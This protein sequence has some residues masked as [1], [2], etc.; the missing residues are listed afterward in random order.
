MKRVILT[1]ILVSACGGQIPQDG[2]Q[3]DLRNTDAPPITQVSDGIYRGK[4]PDLATLQKLVDMGVQYDIDLEDDQTA[5]DN[6][7]QMAAQVGLTFISHPMSGFWSP[8]DGEVNQ[9]LADISANQPVFVH[10]QHGQ[11]RTGLIIALYR[12]FYEGWAAKDAYKEM[13]DM[14]FHKALFLLNHYF[15]EKTGYED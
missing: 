2:A 3:Q 13:I 1:A 10:C 6:E 12:V 11:D 5:I 4:R 7:T 9:I 14:G 15:E 8:D